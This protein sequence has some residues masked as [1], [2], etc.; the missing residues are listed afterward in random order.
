MNCKHIAIAGLVKVVRVLYTWYA[1]RRPA[2]DASLYHS[3]RATGR[4]IFGHNKEAATTYIT[5]I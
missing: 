5:V 2:T 4:Y 1:D 3:E